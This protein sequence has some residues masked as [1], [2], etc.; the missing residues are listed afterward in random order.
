MISSFMILQ[1]T[2][3]GKFEYSFTSV[4]IRLSEVVTKAVQWSR[5]WLTI[6]TELLAHLLL[7]HY[8]PKGPKRVS[9]N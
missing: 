4:M 9:K 5:L 8:L 7:Y 2:V 3:G 6:H 1:S